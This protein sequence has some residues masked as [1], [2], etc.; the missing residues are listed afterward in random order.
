MATAQAPIKIPKGSIQYWPVQILSAFG[1]ITTLDGKDCR[2]DLYKADDDET[3]IVLNAAAEN[4]GMIALPLI[5]STTLDEGL[6]KVF[7]SFVASPQTPKL[8]PFYFQVDD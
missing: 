6:Y 8:G 1:T 5:D 7:I 4:D 3:D 2:Y